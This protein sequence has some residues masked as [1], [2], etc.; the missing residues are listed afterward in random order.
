M[1]S[2]PGSQ[3]AS[4]ERD[5][6]LRF[7]LEL[8]DELALDEIAEQGAGMPMRRRTRRTGF[9]LDGDRRDVRRAEPLFEVRL[10]QQADAGGGINHS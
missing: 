6:A 4:P 10:I 9:E 3:N 1:T 7:A 2:P 8:E 5:D